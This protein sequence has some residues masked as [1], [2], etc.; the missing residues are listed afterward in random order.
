MEQ[1]GQARERGK[2]PREWPRDLKLKA[3][4]FSQ[5]EEVSGHPPVSLSTLSIPGPSCCVT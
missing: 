1:E 2:G 5:A 4:D 3:Q